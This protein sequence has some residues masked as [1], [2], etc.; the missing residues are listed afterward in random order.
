MQGR[1]GDAA[2]WRRRCHHGVA[3]ALRRPRI[4]AFSS[5]VWKRPLPNLLQRKRR[6]GKT[7]QIRLHR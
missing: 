2:R 1:C 3:H 6:Q 5:E 7:F 4:L